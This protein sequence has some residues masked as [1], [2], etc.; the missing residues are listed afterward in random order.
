MH[1]AVWAPNAARVSVVGDFNA[2]E[3]RTHPDAARGHAGVWEI[4]LPG[5]GAGPR[6]KF[7]IRDQRGRIFQKADPFGRW[8]EAPPDT[9]SVVWQGSYTWRDEAWM[10]AR[11]APRAAA[12][13]SVYEVHLGSWKRA[14]TVAAR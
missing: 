6:Y 2:W 13:M 9:A 11:S 5:L 1:F 3:G 8:F 10:A 12:P 4:F 7:E 14:D